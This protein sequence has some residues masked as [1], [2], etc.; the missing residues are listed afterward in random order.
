MHELALGQ[1]IVNQV[2][3]F[4]KREH[5]ANISRVRVA[6][7]A[8]CGVD[9]ESLRFGFG[10]A[11]EGTVAEGAVLDIEQLPLVCRCAQCAE[12]FE[13]RGAHAPCPRCGSRKVD[14][15]SGRE[16]RVDS[17]DAEP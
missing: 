4:A 7:G 9:P 6:V 2:V 3:D 5:V 11:A 13:P 15:L 16:L 8:G 12:S 1:S 10:V 14:L 17:F